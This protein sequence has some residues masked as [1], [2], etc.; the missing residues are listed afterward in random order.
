MLVFSVHD[1]AS[2]AACRAHC[3]EVRE[4]VPDAVVVCCGVAGARVDRR[5]MAGAGATADDDDDDGDAEAPRVVAEAEGRALCEELGVEYFEV[6]VRV[7]DGRV[8]ALF[9][10]LARAVMD[11]EG[12]APEVNEN[13]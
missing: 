8:D 1:R 3:A 9:R 13:V 4:H 12:L 6:D 11:R 7:N 5:H 2:F 10:G